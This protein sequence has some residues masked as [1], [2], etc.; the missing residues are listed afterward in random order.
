MAR[1]LTRRYGR[2]LALDRIDLALPPGAFCL[3]LGAN[4]AGKSTLLR[5]LEGV[6]RPDAGS[7]LFGDLPIG[8]GPWQHRRRTGGL[9]H[10]GRAYPLATVRQNLKFAH[11]LAYADAPAIGT[12]LTRLGLETL[13]DRPAGALS[14]GQRQRLELALALARAPRLLLLD[15]PFAGLDAA[16]AGNLRTYLAGLPEE[17]TVILATHEPEAVWELAD[18]VA[19]LRDGHLVFDCAA[20]ETGPA[21]ALQAVSEG[22]PQPL[23]PAVRPAR[24]AVPAFGSWSDFVHLARMELSQVWRSRRDAAALF[25]FAL[26]IMLTVSLALQ[27]PLADAADAAIGGFWAS[28]VFAAVSGS[29]Y[30][31]P[32]LRQSGGLDLLLA[33]PLARPAILASQVL[34]QLARLLPTALVGL[35][36]ASIF[37]EANLLTPAMIAIAISGAVALSALAAAYGAL[38]AM[39]GGRAVLGPLLMLPA[40]LPVVLAGVLS[41]PAAIGQTNVLQTV[42]AVG[43]GLAYAA[44]VGAVSVLAIEEILVE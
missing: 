6:I 35:L 10:R 2:T 1:A 4:G 28:L 21:A 37:F 9:G 30:G 27:T 14:A 31:F 20:T 38:L 8:C 5:I 11:A 36:A 25:T 39:A 19:G 15:E 12:L 18:R 40:A 32:L 24:P 16:S 43:L 22:T 34:A 7:A 23:G 13:A 26:L 17:V 29:Q 33:L 44:L 3:L 42:Q 41:G